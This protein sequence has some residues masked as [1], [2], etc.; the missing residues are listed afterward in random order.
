MPKVT[1][2]DGSFALVTNKPFNI[3]KDAV[4]AIPALTASAGCTPFS[5]AS[6]VMTID[7]SAMTIP[8]D[9]SI[10]AVKIISVCPMANK[11]TTMT[12]CNTKDKLSPVKN[13][14]DWLAKNRQAAA[15]AI[16]GPSAFQGMGVEFLVMVCSPCCES[17]S[18]K[19]K[20][21]S[22]IIRDPYLKDGRL[23]KPLRK[24]S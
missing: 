15:S 10:P 24:V 9:K 5:T 20:K 19:R 22:K 4:T 2:N 1:I 23:Q 11:P 6:L 14:S 12:C 7:P 21:K 18:Q 8:Q 16:Q 13:L 17:K 3:P